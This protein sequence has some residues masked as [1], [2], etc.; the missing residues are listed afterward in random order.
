MTGRGL[1]RIEGRV[2]ASKVRKVLTGQAGT[3]SFWEYVVE[4]KVDGESRR[5]TLKQAASWI[6]GTKM[7]NVAEGHS[8]PLLLD[9]KSGKVRFDVKD[10]RINRAAVIKRERAKQDAKFN[11]AKSGS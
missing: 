8:V 7:I 10:P 3:Q 1:E 9:R 2:I 6:W 11:R 5:A 4:Y